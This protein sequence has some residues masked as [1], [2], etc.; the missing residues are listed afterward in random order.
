MPASYNHNAG[1]PRRGSQ[2]SHSLHVPWR[3][4]GMSKLFNIESFTFVHSSEMEENSARS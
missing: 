1:C 3:G 4:P 2:E